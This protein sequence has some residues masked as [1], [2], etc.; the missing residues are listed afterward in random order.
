MRS[1]TQRVL[2]ANQRMRPQMK[3]ERPVSD[4][5][6]KPL[7][8]VRQVADFLAVSVPTVY[9]LLRSGR[10]KGVKVGGQ[11]RISSEAVRQL[12]EDQIHVLR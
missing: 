4:G 11:W 8:N 10:L 5:R 1:P 6:P 7:D 12:L 9:R 3:M 2:R